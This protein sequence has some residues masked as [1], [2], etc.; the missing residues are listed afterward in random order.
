MLASHMRWSRLFLLPLVVVTQVGCEADTKPDGGDRDSRR[1]MQM[2][3][4][5]TFPEPIG[6][7]PLPRGWKLDTQHGP[8]EPTIT[9]PD[10]IAVYD[11]PFRMFVFPLNAQMRQVYR[12]TR[13]KTRRFR[14]MQQ[15]I[16]RDFVPVATK[17]G[18]TLL[19]TTNA[20]QVAKYD[21]SY[22][23]QLWQV[24]PAKKRFEAAVTEWQDADG[25]P[26]M[27]LI[28]AMI[29]EG[30][31]AQTWG[32]SSMT[33]VASPEAYE[34]AKKDLLYATVNTEYSRKYIAEYN[35]QEQQKA[36][37]SWSRHRRKMKARQDAFDAQQRAH[38]ANSEAANEAIMGGWR[39][40]NAASDRAQEAY[41][42]SIR[43]EQN[44]RDPDTGKVYKVESGSKEYWKN[45]DNEYI[46]SDDLFYNPN[47]DPGVDH[48][49]WVKM[50]EAR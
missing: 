4:S 21:E 38:R 33:L 40:R 1:V 16:E 17:H 19:R 45:A 42:D 24:A 18:K 23:A 5:P 6:R 13:Q 39:E 28:R 22:N 20:P 29:M 14:S 35:R 30:Q 37:A 27:I 41:V 15:I 49:D 11:A 46:E 12:Q 50:E 3:T 25:N 34:Q 36:N 7:V 43:E 9:G 47:T 31:G 10:G 44:M 2:V 48:Q 8:N 26:G 32:Y